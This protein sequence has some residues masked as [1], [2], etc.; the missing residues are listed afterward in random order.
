MLQISLDYKFSSYIKS[1]ENRTSSR[2]ITIPFSRDI[3][4]NSGRNFIAIHFLTS[5]ENR[6]KQ[7]YNKLPKIQRFSFNHLHPH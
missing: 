5:Q 2:V 3:H 1:H 7:D 6:S 4:K